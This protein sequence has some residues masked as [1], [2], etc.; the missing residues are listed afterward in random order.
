MNCEGGDQ[1]SGASERRD[2][3]N[4]RV[5]E[6][7]LESERESPPKTAKRSV[8]GK[9]GLHAAIY[10]MLAA[11]TPF[12]NRYLSLSTACGLMKGTKLSDKHTT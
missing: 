8:G 4:N 6:T 2:E 12:V 11:M 5:S 3:Q 9:C 1:A 7:E 10:R